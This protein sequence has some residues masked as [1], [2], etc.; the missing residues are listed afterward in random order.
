M[1]KNNGTVILMKIF[2]I[3]EKEVTLFWEILSFLD[4]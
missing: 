2:Y 1:S 3:P 4:I